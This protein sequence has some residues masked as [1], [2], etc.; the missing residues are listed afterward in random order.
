MR[1]LLL[2]LALVVAAALSTAIPARADSPSAYG[3]VREYHAAMWA[4]TQR[5]HPY[6]WGGTGPGY[7]CSGLVYAAFRHTGLT[8]PRTTYGML[9]SWHLVRTYHPKAGDLAF[10]SRG[11]VELVTRGH[12]RTFGSSHPGTTVGVRSWAGSWY[13]PVMFFRVR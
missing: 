9:A 4:Y 6:V 10:Y 5:G 13:R 7:D 8:L 1:R 3:T 2:L 12:D 11:H